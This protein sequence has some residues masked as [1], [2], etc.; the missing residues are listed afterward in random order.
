M[1]Q[2]WILNHHGDERQVKT[3]EGGT[4]KPLQATPEPSQDGMKTESSYDPNLFLDAQYHNDNLSWILFAQDWAKDAIG[5][6]VPETN[7]TDNDFNQ[8]VLRGIVDDPIIGFSGSHTF[9]EGGIPVIGD[10]FKTATSTLNE[11]S[12]KGAAMK[13]FFNNI[14]ESIN[15]KSLT[16]N[17]KTVITD[18][19]GGAS[20]KLA[21]GI[22]KIIDEVDKNMGSQFVTSFDHIKVYKGTDLQVDYGSLST[23][24]YYKQWN[25]LGT[26]DVVKL[27]I[28]RFVGGFEPAKTNSV[29]DEVVGLQR[30]PNG[31]VPQ[32]YNLG[33]GD[34]I[35]GS[36]VLQ[37]C[38]HRI[39]NLL[40][41]TFNWKFSTFKVRTSNTVQVDG[42]T[43]KYTITPDQDPLYVDVSIDLIPATRM[44]RDIMEWV[45]QIRGNKT[46]SSGS[47]GSR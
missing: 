18:T 17:A 38:G 25:A 21:S 39:P 13:G 31:Y 12:S 16:E 24:I 19:L 6:R 8:V 44:S 7:I 3:K 28:N 14:S 22:N 27:L 9:S 26:K 32:F 41:N 33:V 43:N 46:T 10:M 47:S 15:G 30:P 35:P 5:E 45:M 34:R 42:D 37:Y 4:R 23:R 1:K 40:V 20:T 29:L 36:F 2:L 11:W